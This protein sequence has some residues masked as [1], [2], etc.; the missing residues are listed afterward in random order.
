MKRGD[1]IEVEIER[2]A[3]EGKSVARVEG[4]VVF[5]HGGVP[6]DRVAVCVTAVKKAFAE[7]EIERVV[8]PSPLRVEPRCRYF[9]SCGGCR[10]QHVAYSAQLEFKRQ[11]VTD[12]LERIGGF[13]GIEVPHPLGGPDTFHYRN[14]MEFSFGERWRTREE[15]AARTDPEGR[16][17]AA[18]ALGLHVAERYDRILDL[19]ECYL[20]SEE[21]AAIVNEVRRYCIERAL[22]VY[23]TRTQSGY[24]RN[25][26]IREA[27]R[28]GERMINLVTRD[29]RPD[30]MGPMAE[31]LH[32][33]FPSTTTIVNNITQRRSQV[34][35]GETEKVYFGSGT[36]TDRI[37]NRTYR[38]SANSFFQTNTERTERLYDTARRM[39]EFRAEDTVYDLYSGTGTIA[40]HVADD[41]RSVFGIEA[42]AGAVADARRNAELNGVG[43]CTFVEGDLKD[44]L[45]RSRTQGGTIPSP[46]VVIVDPPRAGMHEKVVRE[47]LALRPRRIVYISCNPATQARDAKI[48]C[49]SYA[50]RIVEV[51]PVDMFPH[52]YHIEN[53]LSLSLNPL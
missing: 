34:A 45:L 23:S 47:L 29:D 53:V 16:Q 38:I 39:A 4:L 8:R 9:G 46:D 24:L 3:Y 35:V 27:R 52:T 40:L 43:N 33:R 10:W 49:E 13:N 12:A 48:L 37:G 17:P 41:V 1:I 6:G 18:F 21:S 44:T 28:T 51:Q 30:I 19:E 26:V 11:Q 36:I 2:A 15:M 31:H 25:L 50:Y 32:A 5:V 7:S 22:P 42:V 14:K 20:Q